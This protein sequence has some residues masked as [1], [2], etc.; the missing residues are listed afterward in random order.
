MPRKMTWKRQKLFNS[1]G[2]KC[3]LCGTTVLL[4]I[5]HIK[6]VIKGGDSKDDNCLIVCEDCHKDIHYPNRKS[7]A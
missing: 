1:R 5:H 3:E 6:E 4:E 7:R 2:E